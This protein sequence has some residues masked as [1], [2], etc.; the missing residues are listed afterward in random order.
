MYM[1]AIAYTFESD[2]GAGVIHCTFSP[3][4]LKYTFPHQSQV[5]GNKNTWAVL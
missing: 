3:T 2:K 1:I 5:Q 4:N